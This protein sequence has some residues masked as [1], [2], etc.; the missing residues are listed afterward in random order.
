MVLCPF[1]LGQ[2]FFNNVMS[3]E[4]CFYHIERCRACW[5]TIDINVFQH[6]PHLICS[7]WTMRLRPYALDASGDIPIVTGIS[8]SLTLSKSIVFLFLDLCMATWLW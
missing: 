7:E 8:H 2:W 4:V 6:N 3:M 1:F 5:A